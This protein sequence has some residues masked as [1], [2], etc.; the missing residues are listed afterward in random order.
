[1][2]RRVLSSL[3]V[4]ALVAGCSGQPQPVAQALTQD[5]SPGPV[6]HKRVCDQPMTWQ[7]KDPANDVPDKY[8]D[9]KGLW[10][11]DVDFG[12]ASMCI[13]IAVSEVTAAGDVNTVLV[14]NIG[15]SPASNGDPNT[16]SEGKA[17]NWWAKDVK[18]GA[19]GEEIVF[20]SNEPYHGLMWEYRFS[21]P[22]TDKM[23]GAL[24][25]HKMDGTT[26]SKFTAV[27]TRKTPAAPLVAD[28]GK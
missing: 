11:G 2:K 6:Q 27:L 19:K 23:V 10:T 12:G 1:M 21:L 9:L 8:K 22:K 24:I 25:A 26:A 4:L 18:A 28:S 14:W 7:Y 17:T 13:G 3:S 5:S 16:H 20:S 15:A